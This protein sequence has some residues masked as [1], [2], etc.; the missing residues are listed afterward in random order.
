M[1]QGF[2]DIRGG[3]WEHVEIL[4][5]ATLSSLFSFASA[6]H[7]GGALDFFFPSF[8]FFYSFLYF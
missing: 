5:V 1:K 4:R 6:A 8:F 2:G 3:N 7:R